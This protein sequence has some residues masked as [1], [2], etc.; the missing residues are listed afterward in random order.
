MSLAQRAKS[1]VNALFNKSQ[2]SLAAGT[3]TDTG[4]PLKQGRYLQHDLKSISQAR[5]DIKDMKR[6]RAL[7]FSQD[8]KTWMLQ[9][10]LSDIFDDEVLTSQKENRTQQVHARDIRLKKPNGEVDTVQT[11][12]LKKM[13]I[14]R[15]LTEQILDAIYFEYS[16]CELS[17]NQTI[18]GNTYLVGD[19]TPRTNIIPQSGVFYPDY[20]NTTGGIK[21]RDM[22]EYGIWILEFWTKKAPLFNKAI[23]AVLF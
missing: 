19:V 23:P 12:A 9:L 13:P 3:V 8:P 21:Y 7:Y 4:M 17:M 1:A 18:D 6:A 2:V 5:R 16:V 10:L 22:E 14:R 11:D 20:M 15:F